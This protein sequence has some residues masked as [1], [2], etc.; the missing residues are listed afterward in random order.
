METRG[1]NRSGV[2]VPKGTCPGV[3]KVKFTPA[4]WYKWLNE[5]NNA[6]TPGSTAFRA[7]CHEPLDRGSENT[8]SAPTRE[9][10]D[11]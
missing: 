11:K 4:L 8:Y 3:S 7:L 10:E 9:G 1:K 6:P 5:F 2:R